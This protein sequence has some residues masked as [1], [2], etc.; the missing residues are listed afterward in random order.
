MDITQILKLSESKTLEFKQ[1]LSSPEGVLRTLVAFANTSGGTLVIGVEDKTRHVRGISDPLLLEERLANIISD[2]ISPRLVPNIELSPWRDTYIILV[3]IYPSNNRPHYLKNKGV[4]K[5]TYVRIGSTNRVADSILIKELSRYTLSESYDEEPMPAL[6]SEAIDFRVASELFSEYRKLKVSD[7]ETLK[8]MTKYQ[9]RMVPTVG[10]MI[11]FGENRERYFPDAWIQAGRFKGT[12]K[13]DILDSQEIRAYPVIAVDEA[14]SF[15]KKH[16][17]HSVEIS[18]LRR[19]EQWTIPLI[20]IREAIINAIVH[21]DYSQ[22]GAPIRIAI[23]DDRIEIENPGLIPFNL[24]LDD[25]YH[26]ISK[27]RNPVIGRIFHELKLIERWGSGIKRMIEAC[28]DAGLEKPFLEEIGTHFRV[29]FFTEKKHA[30]RDFQLDKIDEAILRSLKNGKGLSTQQI[31]DEIDRSSR[32]TRS[33]LIIL[34]ARGLVVEIG[35]SPKD[36]KRKYYL[37]ENL[38]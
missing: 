29:T 23:F 37:A 27:L 15:I 1:D 24:T 13:K 4:E 33:R 30:K 12:H 16:L 26:G 18:G 25:L 31:A 9:G 32:S 17:M 6:S 2:S 10:G 38:R 11:L 20:A 28:L 3:Q 35:S 7:L 8:V 19:K 5:G 22:R 14:A 36:P 34:V 21:A